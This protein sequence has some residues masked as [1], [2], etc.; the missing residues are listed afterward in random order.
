MERQKTFLKHLSDDNDFTFTTKLLFSAD[1]R[2]LKI[3]TSKKPI[4]YVSLLPSRPN[5][6]PY[7][8]PVWG[9]TQT[10][11]KYDVFAPYVYICY[12]RH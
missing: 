10:R 3:K 1:L 8:L 4:G 11:R 12:S 2:T 9:A 7:I 6:F 5:T